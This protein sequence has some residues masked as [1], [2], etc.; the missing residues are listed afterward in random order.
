MD[1]NQKEQAL[2]AQ[3]VSIG[4]DAEPQN[5][6]V[7]TY[8]HPRTFGTFPRILAKY[9]REEKVITLENAIREMT[10]LPANQLKLRDRGRISEGM[11]ADLVLFD[12]HKIQDTATFA[13]PLSYAEG[14]D[15]V[16]INGQL[17]IDQ[18]QPT[19]ALPGK[20]LRAPK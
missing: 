18:A 7:S 5:P 9:V 8:A 2:R 11:A 19:N 13:K 3:F 1:E 4:S 10:S 20:I 16:V 15:Y 12:P 17:A 6:A 14:I